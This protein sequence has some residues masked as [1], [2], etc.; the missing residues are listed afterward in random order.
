MILVLIFGALWVYAFIRVTNRL[1][2]GDRTKKN[3]L[4]FFSII[5]YWIFGIFLIIYP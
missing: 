1:I 4:I 3:W 5:A 2:N